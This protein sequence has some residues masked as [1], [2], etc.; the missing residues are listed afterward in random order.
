[1]QQIKH[2]LTA[3]FLFTTPLSAVSQE[4]NYSTTYLFNFRVI[5][6]ITDYIQWNV[7]GKYEVNVN[8]SAVK[9]GDISIL[10]A[11]YNKIN[12]FHDRLNYEMQQRILMPEHQ[13]AETA[14]T[15]WCKGKEVQSAYIRLETIDKEEKVMVTEVMRFVPDSSI[16]AFTA[17]INLPKEAEML[18]IKIGGTGKQGMD[19]YLAFK[20]LR[21]KVGDVDIDQFPLRRLPS[22]E[23]L[24]STTRNLI[25][26]LQHA[27]SLEQMREVKGRRILALG[28]TL[29]NNHP[30]SW[31][32]N[33]AVMAMVRE[34]GCRLVLFELPLAQS[35]AYNRFIHDADFQL[36]TTDIRKDYYA[37]LKDLRDFNRE[38]TDKVWFFGFDYGL[39][40]E[41]D[42]RQILFDF[43]C[44][45]NEK[46]KLTEAKRL[47]VLVA[48]APSSEVI[49][50]IEGQR[51]KLAPVISVDEQDVLAHIMQQM[52]VLKNDYSRSVEAR[53]SMMFVHTQFFMNRFAKADSR[54]II[55][56][57][58]GHVNPISTYPAVPCVPF[59]K[60]MQDE[61]GKDYC[62][63]M[64]TVGDKGGNIVEGRM[65][66]TI[67]L[68][69]K[70]NP[71]SSI[72]YLLNEAG[73]GT[74]VYCPMTADFDRLL[75]TRMRGKISLNADFYPYNPAQRFDAVVYV[76]D[77]KDD[78]STKENKSL[79]QTM[80][81][82]IKRLRERM[83]R[84]TQLKRQLNP[85]TATVKKTAVRQKTNTRKTAK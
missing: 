84:L 10:A 18:D 12:P 76:D 38:R 3:L 8:I 40:Q 1:M 50:Y 67:Y 33:D 45:L 44:R 63:V 61:Y 64:L 83:E 6:K 70:E 7:N 52:D 75:L 65:G 34:Q 21:I 26:P 31:F 78:A 47:A 13:E 72:E 82:N 11:K 39:R 79:E 62:R 20:E 41:A 53:D 55:K 14:V 69:L 59:G 74:T 22:L 81:L 30:I 29:H 80:E 48:E 32:T 56:A 5:P 71:A 19:A 57:H 46:K 68:K 16:H 23:P 9:T 35:L 17:K 37:L 24:V 27:A 49:T 15:L 36:D 25:T 60:Y 85:S 2:L 66:E 77:S 73:G 54:V 51:E 4:Q 42:I 28:E 43:V 58:A